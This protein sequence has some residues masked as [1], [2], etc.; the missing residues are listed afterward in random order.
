MK[1]FPGLKILFLFL[2][3]LFLAA[4]AIDRP[5]TG[6]PPDT[7]PLSVTAST[8]EPGTVNVSPRTIRLDFSHYVGREELAK[9]IFFTPSVD[10]YEVEM[11]GREARIRIFSPLRPNRTY[12]LTLRNSLKSLH[13]SHRLGESWALAFSTGPVIDRG[14]MEGRVWTNRMEA[15]PDVT[16]MATLASGSAGQSP[17]YLTRTGPSGEFRFGHLA[18]GSYRIVAITDRNGNLRFD[19][20]NELFAAAAAQT[21]AAG[22]PVNLRL[23]AARQSTPVPRSCRTINN[24]EIE[25]TFSQPVRAVNFDPSAFAIETTDSGKPL[26]ILGF[27]SLSRSSESAT[28]RLLTGVMEKEAWYRLRFAS[29]PRSSEL[30]FQGNARQERYPALSLAIIPAGGSESVIAETIRPG[31]APAAELHFNLPVDESSLTPRAVRLDLNGPNGGTRS[32]PCTIARIDSRTFAVRPTGGFLPG[33]NYTLR[34][35]MMKIKGVA[36]EQPANAGAAASNFTIAD[37]VAYGEISGSGKAV[38]RQIVIEARMQGTDFVK[39]LDISPS[40][41]SGEFR[42]GFSGLP[43]GK[44]AVTAF[45]PSRSPQASAPASWNAGSAEPFTPA[46]A[47]SAAMVEV[48]AGWSTDEVRLDMPFSGHENPIRK[49][50]PENNQRTNRRP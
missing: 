30:L 22:H 45:I 27:F 46:V 21:P 50:N 32:V 14:V 49:N 15:A 28:W 1:D 25:L 29:A 40:A 39:R 41:K 26:S 17:E 24:R 6:G 19:P 2:L 36:G 20:D 16:V 8:P 44:Y 7:A 42:F 35:D 10:D 33:R 12:T 38:A 9:S 34:V 4:C 23:S 48:R 5:P 18:P 47:F 37:E 13:G 11:R 3:P 31:L 43:P